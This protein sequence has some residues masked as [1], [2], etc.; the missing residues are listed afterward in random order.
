M[1]FITAAASTCCRGT[2][3]KPARM[4]SER[5]AVEM[6][7]M[8]ITAIPNSDTCTPTAWV[9]NMTMNRMTRNGMR[10]NIST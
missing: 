2:E 6:M 4:I 9:A 8:P 7:Q 3:S 5:K 10:R 1:K